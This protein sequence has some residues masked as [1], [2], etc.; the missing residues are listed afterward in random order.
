M[1]K[2]LIFLSLIAFVSCKSD[3][4]SSGNDNNNKTAGSNQWILTIDG[5]TYVW[6]AYAA[7]IVGGGMTTILVN[8]TD[9][10][11]FMDKVV[12][13]GFTNI[14]TIGIYDIGIT[15]QNGGIVQYIVPGYTPHDTTDYSTPGFQSLSVGKM[16]ITEITASTLKATFYETLSKERGIGSDSVSITNGSVNVTF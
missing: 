7:K 16:T 5:T 6:K 3:S 4:A 12:S 8:S 11:S 13:F 15:T 10:V 14:S 9:T 2:F 1:K